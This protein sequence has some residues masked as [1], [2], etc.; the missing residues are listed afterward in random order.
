[1][2]GTTG[3]L[4]ANS[5][6]YANYPNFV[7]YALKLDLAVNLESKSYLLSWVKDTNLFLLLFLNNV[8]VIAVEYANKLLDLIV[9][10][11][12]RSLIYFK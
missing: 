2:S 8:K 10:A 3:S 12:F 6:H 9:V 5:C 1:M 11:N 7:G 4:A